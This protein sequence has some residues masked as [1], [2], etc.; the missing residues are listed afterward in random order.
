MFLLIYENNLGD[1]RLITIY[2]ALIT[3]DALVNYLPPQA[4]GMIT[5]GN[6]DSDEINTKQKDISDGYEVKAQHF[7]NTTMESGLDFLEDS[8]DV[9]VDAFVKAANS[10]DG[11]E[12][13][14]LYMQ[15][16]YDFG[17]HTHCIQDFY[18]HTNWIN[19][20]GNTIS[21]WNGNIEN[22]NIDNPEKLKTSKYSES[23]QIWDSLCFWRSNDLKEGIGYE[24]T[25]LENTNLTHELLNKDKPGTIADKSFEAKEGVSGFD[26]ACSDATIHTSKEW[27]DVLEEVDDQ[28]DD[29]EYAAFL[30]DLQEFSPTEEEIKEYWP[31]CA[32]EFN[33]AMKEEGNN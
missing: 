32:K 10:A 18:S 24:E 4:I 28:L 5:R 30:E 27:Q 1:I 33:E 21:L 19:Q 8:E 29:E 13:E 16:L 7:N 15:A 20:T 25:Y 23:K 14:E 9:T 6:V 2:H 22:A 31:N 17:R 3:N 12:K 26:L 11:D